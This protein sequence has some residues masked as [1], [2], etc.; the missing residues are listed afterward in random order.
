MKQKLETH[1]AKNPSNHELQFHH[2]H[3]T[4]RQRSLEPTAGL[5]ANFWQ[6]VVKKYQEVMQCAD[7]QQPEEPTSEQIIDGHQLSEAAKHYLR[8][9]TMGYRDFK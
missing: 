3:I 8:F 5:H 7:A 1:D 2:L 9:H 6:S 4:Q